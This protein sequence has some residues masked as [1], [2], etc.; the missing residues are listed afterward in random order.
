MEAIASAGITTAFG[1]GF[2]SEFIRDT[3]GF[4]KNSSQ[5]PQVQDTIL[6]LD[7]K[8]FLPLTQNLVTYLETQD[9]AIHIKL[10]VQQLKGSV[11][12]I[13][14]QLA[15]IQNTLTT[16]KKKFLHSIRPP[17]L[18][19]HLNKLTVLKTNADKQMNYILHLLPHHILNDTS[20]IASSR[21]PVVKYPQYQN[22]Q[23]LETEQVGP[24]R[25][26]NNY[27][28][29]AAT[30]APTVAITNQPSVSTTSST[31]FYSGNYDSN[32][33]HDDPLKL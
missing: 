6:Q 24:S 10:A 21:S 18:T 1:N 31:S 22:I 23:E 13:R 26:S 14:D 17:S 5:F 16:H 2:L 30:M 20:N 11:L 7:L 9:L 19:K 29:T 33:S 25:T 28:T 32:E 12:L 8:N 27:N 3:Y 4:I 15:F